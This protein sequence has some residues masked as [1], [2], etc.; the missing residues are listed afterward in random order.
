MPR[1]KTLCGAQR[2]LS[3]LMVICF[4]STVIIP[5]EALAQGVLGLP[6][7]GSL[8]SL[9]PGL[10]PVLLRGIQINQDNPFKFNFVIDSGN[11]D[12]SEA[13]LRKESE[14]IARYFL[15]TLAIPEED[16]W[17][18]LSPYEK[19]RIVPNELGQT[20]MGRDL[21]AQ[22]YLLKQITASLIYPEGEAGR[23]FWEKV[24][25]ESFE[26][27]GTTQIPINTFNKVWIVPD[28]AVVYQ[29]G[30]RAFVA[31]S[32]LKVML[33]QDYLLLESNVSNENLKTN[34]Q[35]KSQTEDVSEFSSNIVREVIIPLLETEVNEGKN[36][37]Q[38]R[39]VYHAMILAT[40]FKQTLKNSILNKFYINQKKVEGIN[41][42]DP[43]VIEEIYTQYV[44]SFKKGAYDLLKIEYDPHSQKHI[45]RKYFSGGFDAKAISSN[46]VVKKSPSLRKSV[47]NS[48]V[49]VMFAAVFM[50][51]ASNN[52][53]ASDRGAA[54]KNK[55]QDVITQVDTTDSWKQKEIESYENFQKAQTNPQWGLD[56]IRNFSEEFWYEEFLFT[57]PY[58]KLLDF[59]N[60]NFR[61]IPLS[62]LRDVKNIVEQRTLFYSVGK[63]NVKAS[64]KNKN[65]GARYQKNR[66]R[67]NNYEK[68]GERQAEESSFL[69]KIPDLLSWFV[70]SYEDKI[71]KASKN[72]GK[73]FKIEKNFAFDETKIQ[74]MQKDG[75][76]SKNNSKKRNFGETNFPPMNAPLGYFSNGDFKVPSSLATI[77]LLRSSDSWIQETFDFLGQN[78]LGK[79]LIEWKHL[80]HQKIEEYK[81]TGKKDP[82]FKSYYENE[83]QEIV[84]NSIYN[85]LRDEQE[86][87]RYDK[88]VYKLY[89]LPIN[90]DSLEYFLE[91]GP[92][93]YA[94]QEAFRNN[95]D[96]YSDKIIEEVNELINGKSDSLSKKDAVNNLMEIFA[97]D[98]SAS[99]EIAFDNIDLTKEKLREVNWE[100]YFK[101]IINTKE[102]GVGY[103]VFTLNKDFG[104]HDNPIIEA[105]DKMDYH[106]IIKDVGEDVDKLH[107]LNEIALTFGSTKL[108]ESLKDVETENLMLEVEKGDEK[109]RSTLIWLS[110]FNIGAS[111]EL[112][113]IEN[114]ERIEKGEQTALEKRVEEYSK[115]KIDYA[116]WR[117]TIETAQFE[118]AISGMAG[119]EYYSGN[120]FSFTRADEI[121]Y[122]DAPHIFNFSGQGLSMLTINDFDFIDRKQQTKLWEHLNFSGFLKDGEFKFDNIHS[123]S[124]NNPVTSYAVLRDFENIFI[125]N[126]LMDKFDPE[127]IMD[128]RFH[129]NLISDIE[130]QFSIKLS[131]EI[132]QNPAT[133]REILHDIM[134][135][136]AKATLKL[137]EEF[138]P[139]REQICTTLVKNP[140]VKIQKALSF[141]DKKGYLNTE[142][143]LP[144]SKFKGRTQE[145]FDDLPNSEFTDK[146]KIAIG[147]GLDLLNGVF[148]PSLP[149]NE[150]E[151]RTILLKSLEGDSDATDVLRKIVTSG[152]SDFLSSVKGAMNELNIN[153][154]MDELPEDISTYLQAVDRGFINVAQ[155]EPSVFSDL[156]KMR[157][158]PLTKEN[159]KDYT[160]AAFVFFPASDYNGAFNAEAAI[161]DLVDKGYYVYFASGSTVNELEQEL[162][163]ST[164]G[165][166]FDVMVYG[167]HGG[168][169][170]K[171]IHFGRENRDDTD[172]NRSISADNEKDV[173]KII[174]PYLAENGDVVVFSCSTGFGLDKNPNNIGNVMRR[175]LPQAGTIFTPTAPAV[176]F[177]IVFDEEGKVQSVKYTTGPRS[178]PQKEEI[179]TYEASIPIEILLMLL[180]PGRRIRRIGFK[181][182]NGKV[183]YSEELWGPKMMKK[184]LKNLLSNF[185]SLGFSDLEIEHGPLQEGLENFDEARG[186]VTNEFVSSDSFQNENTINLR[187]DQEILL[188]KTNLVPDDPNT[189]T[190]IPAAIASSNA[191]GG[192][193]EMTAN[194]A[195]KISSDQFPGE[196][197][198]LV[199]GWNADFTD[200]IYQ[201]LENRDSED[202]SLKD[203][204]S[205]EK[206]RILEMLNEH[207][208]SAVATNGTTGLTTLVQ[209]ILDEEEDI[210][211]FMG[212]V[213]PSQYERRF[214]MLNGKKK[215]VFDEYNYQ[216]DTDK[217]MLKFLLDNGV[218]HV[219]LVEGGIRSIK[220]KIN[221]FMQ[222]EGVSEEAILPMKIKPLN[223]K[224]IKEYFEKG[225]NIVINESIEDDKEKKSKGGMFGKLK[226]IAFLSKK[227]TPE[228]KEAS[229]RVENI[230]KIMKISEEIPVAPGTL[231]I[232]YGKCYLEKS[233]QEWREILQERLEENSQ[234]FS[235]DRVQELLEEYRIE[236]GL[237]P[238]PKV[239]S[240][241]V[242]GIDLNAQYLDLKT[243]GVDMDFELPLEWQGVDLNNVPGLVPVFIQMMPILN[244][245]GLVEGNLEILNPQD[246]TMLSMLDEQKS[247][248]P[249]LS[250]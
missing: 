186:E 89:S 160:G 206:E 10:T 25:R 32:R 130:S 37:A 159:K 246:E 241:D 133:T 155:F 14:K 120:T 140:W 191:L 199:R 98:Y 230:K 141:L 180:L 78:D 27:Y 150:S 105:L 38:L 245:S 211:F 57:M 99:K 44:E 96:S 3:F 9:S 131:P 47:I 82:H 132:T 172:Y 170:G 209:Q 116:E 183:L 102:D 221:D 129:P 190:L 223:Q 178:N 137:P 193:I 242:G 54:E 184:L 122:Y 16:L 21:L 189:K 103:R 212:P 145:F 226:K 147:Y 148:A 197:P 110:H 83:N 195:L 70:S 179:N 215:I 217:G 249:S 20:E 76:Y 55:Y 53:F 224:Q 126:E 36:F 238:S 239:S 33:E 161:T 216:A 49:G 176:T 4:L 153:D 204:R 158:N 205:K 214:S 85:N 144:T 243:E 13:D 18:N 101:E 200:N 79:E 17:V 66:A 173:K 208:I 229:I 142:T 90:G 236:N 143:F 100:N 194:E 30:S 15:S 94:N 168:V 177:K 11:L 114:R 84:S 146:D 232:I 210:G 136:D 134:I 139:Y 62:S 73:Y 227:L 40:W 181:N 91:K 219:L 106:S 157:D 92:N 235:P 68:L 29:E 119:K 58:E 8:V 108:R 127:S 182:K 43:R 26:R 188:K 213:S 88:A 46:I 87:A 65:I 71:E 5:S 95:Y 56:N 61:L 115:Q 138:E 28:K 59:W 67:T 203:Y 6:Q 151:V 31:E 175:V 45:P 156:M 113:K 169:G 50:L 1:K 69:D 185:D 112:Q 202:V 77:N 207:T 123:Q 218:E 201:F 104:S 171:S 121:A 247:Q 198:F 111:I 240:P 163:N 39:Q 244:F 125:D 35:D 63:D 250:F 74:Q 237:P 165:T 42:N 192:V 48:V 118:Y 220:T 167:G 162:Q 248:Q 52:L 93:Q 34:G 225:F 117:E 233:E 109:A 22:D 24:Y 174:S 23:R 166:P 228:E 72:K 107:K 196:Y 2:A 19:D 60:N 64:T 187:A 234:V 149:N 86:K 152:L 12:V 124:I 80:V 41:N 135:Q 7:A 222:K 154:R 81:K 231:S 75:T 51:N 128:L 97:T 164:D